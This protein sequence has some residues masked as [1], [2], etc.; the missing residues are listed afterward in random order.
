MTKKILS[1][2][3][4][5]SVMVACMLP[6]IVSADS[7]IPYTDERVVSVGADIKLRAT[8]GTYADGPV[9]L[10]TFNN[11]S[12][13]PKYDFK[14][15][16]DM[17]N[18]QD[19]FS[20]YFSDELFTKLLGQNSSELNSNGFFN[21]DDLKPH[22][23]VAGTMTV[24]INIPEG[25]TVNS[26]FLGTKQMDGFGGSKAIHEETTT[27]RKLENGKIIITTQVKD[28]FDASKKYVAGTTL[29]DGGN[30]NT[31]L[32]EIS[33]E[34]TD[35]T[36]NKFGTHTI[37]GKVEGST[38][39]YLDRNMDGTD[40][41]N[42]EH[43]LG[44]I[45]YETPVV[46]K[47]L[48]VSTPPV[49]GGGG[50]YVPP[51]PDVTVDFSVNGDKQ[52][53]ES[54]SGKNGKV[55]VDLDKVTPPEI[56]GYISDGKWYEDPAH[57]KE[58]SGEYT[59]T[60]NTTLYTTYINMTVPSVL[61]E[62]HHGY[63][64]GYPDGNVKPTKN[65][66]REEVAALLYRLLKEDVRE[67]LRNSNSYF[68][69]VEE[70]RW[71]HS[72]IAAMVKGK[73]IKGYDDG[74]YRPGQPITRAEFATL[75]T[76]FIDEDTLPAISTTFD[77]IGNHWAKE[78]IE[79]AANHMLIAG[80]ENGSFK[81]DKYITRAE[82][83]TILNKILVRHVDEDGLHEDAKHWPDNNEADWYYYQVLEATNSH[84]HDRR[85]NSHLEDWTAHN[86][87]TDWTQH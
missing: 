27:E 82:A 84:D 1:M 25:I 37:S 14:A 9:D 52:V 45:K 70:D 64:Q 17:T 41:L 34:C 44:V 12:D 36:I 59:V 80:Y 57:T 56:E 68:E 47:K 4:V 51:K 21:I 66:T 77:D 7:S 8:G 79:K 24:T 39:I 29:Y 63:I 74:T 31:Y 32:G 87:S 13:V 28:P 42:G 49:Y 85:D 55:T 78:Y 86:E 50:G 11:I 20:Y 65:V 3:L 76:R 38:T 72:E 48:T 81:P 62:D 23:Y 43:I 16:L 46:S 6:A 5:V 19:A 2:F 67:S 75:V 22:L 30:L 58:V 10:G 73:Y 71:S 61:I 53:I 15:T 35:N 54:V 60:E 26:A 83:V 18:V 33:L 40:V 69:D